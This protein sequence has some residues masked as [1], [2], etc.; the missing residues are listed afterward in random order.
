MESWLVHKP[1]V[2]ETMFPE[3][4]ALVGRIDNQCI[5]KLVSLFK[6]FKDFTNTVINGLNSLHV[7]AHHTLVHFDC[8]SFIWSPVL[9]K[10]ISIE[11]I[12]KRLVKLIPLLTLHIC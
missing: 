1:L 8:L 12:R 9:V 5:V 3:E 6:V 10:A 11:G 7:I 4:E 2:E